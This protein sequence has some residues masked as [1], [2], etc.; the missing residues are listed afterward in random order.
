MALERV[1]HLRRNQEQA[2]GLEAVVATAGD[3][4][5][6]LVIAVRQ[7]AGVVDP[8]SASRL[9]T[10]G[11]GVVFEEQSRVVG[12]D[13]RPP[14]RAG[15]HGAAVVA[16]DVDAH[17]RGRHSHRAGLHRMAGPLA[18]HELIF[19]YAVVLVHLAAEALFPLAVGRFAKRLAGGVHA[20]KGVDVIRVLHALGGQHPA[21]DRG[22]GMEQGDA[23]GRHVLQ[24]VLGRGAPG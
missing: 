19:R 18:D 10:A 12:G 11:V 16:D 7:I 1:L 14:D 17:A 13:H 23:Q 9:G 4:E 3:E 5:I 22:H 20:P 6:T 2:A 24:H 21:K 8:V 15:H